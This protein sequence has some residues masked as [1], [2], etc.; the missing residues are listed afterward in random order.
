MKITFCVCVNY[1]F[2]FANH[3]WLFILQIK[4][5]RLNISRRTRVGKKEAVMIIYSSSDCCLSWIK[6]T[7]YEAIVEAAYNN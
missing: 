1:Q 3:T 4:C 6:I 5:R 7:M 2:F